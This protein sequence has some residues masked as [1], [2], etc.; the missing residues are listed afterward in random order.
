MSAYG[1]KRPAYRPCIKVIS[2]NREV[3]N[4]STIPHNHGQ[5]LHNENGPAVVWS[6]GSCEY[7]INGFIHND[8][9]PAIIE[10]DKNFTR[11]HWYINGVQHRVDGPVVEHVNTNGSTYLEYRQDGNLHREDGPA[12][13]HPTGTKIWYVNGVID[14]T[15][16]PAIINMVNDQIIGSQWFISNKDVTKLYRRWATKRKIEADADNFFIFRMEYKILG[17]KL[18]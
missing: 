3:V 10:K 7:Y 17:G 15:D 1:T 16:G 11:K 2:G 4:L 12:V 8:A 18:K 9:G 5:I 14:R 6:D 13:I